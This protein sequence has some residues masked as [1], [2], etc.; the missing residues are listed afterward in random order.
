MKA[1]SNPDELPHSEL[2]LPAL[3]SVSFAVGPISVLAALL[4]IDI[5]NSFGISEVGVTGQ[6]NTLYAIAAVVFALLT[7]AL[8]IRFKHKSLLLAGVLLM[9]VSAVGCF[10]A[11]DFITLL[12]FYSLSGAGYA[13]VN[14]MTFTL[15]GEHFPLQ[16]RASAIGWIVAGGALVYVI[17]APTIAAM[18]GYGGWRFP[19]LGFVLPILLVSLLLAFVGIPLLVSKNQASSDV[20]F[21][22]VPKKILMNKSAVACLVGDTLR[23]A[24]FV[25]VVLYAVSF[26]RE[27]FSVP[28]DSASLILLSGALAYVLGSLCTGRLV[29]RLGR[30]TST[31]LTALLSGTFTIAYVLVPNLW[32][33]VILLLVASWF[34]GMVASSAN[35]LTLEQIPEIKGTLMSVDTA[36]L[37]IG[38]AF[39]SIIGGLVLLYS[40]YGGLGSVLGATGIIAA[41]IYYL[42]TKDPTKPE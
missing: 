1:D 35:S 15:V 14:P 11:P 23:S 2:F 32:V 26:F 7:G 27:Q 5:G 16:K 3:A 8:S 39:G 34:F 30:K 25:A 10:I 6:V 13:I 19:L 29:N 33:S 42:L 40:N 12:A 41:I 4:L 20:N 22:A 21:K 24:A 36:V 17:G 38:S 31:V 28:V 18:S 37:N 9:I